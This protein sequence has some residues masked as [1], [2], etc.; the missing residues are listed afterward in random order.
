M[1]SS[2]EKKNKTNR[3]CL[4]MDSTSLVFRLQKELSTRGSRGGKTNR[5]ATTICTIFDHA[6]SQKWRAWTAGDAAA[7]IYVGKGEKKERG[8]FFSHTKER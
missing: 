5:A 4:C 3:T 2:G 1:N 8:S 6:F 7:M